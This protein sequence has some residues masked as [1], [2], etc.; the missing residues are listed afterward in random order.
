MAALTS[1][2]AT[3]LYTARTMS[4]AATASDV[5]YQGAHV[6]FDTDTGLLIV[7]Q[8]SDTYIPVGIVVKD[9]TIGAG[10]GN[11]LVRLYRELNAVWCV[12]DS[13]DP[14]VTVGAICYMLDDQTVTLDD[15]SNARSVA[16]RVWAIDSTK[17]VLVEFLHTARP[18]ISGLD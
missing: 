4:L 11:V 5:Y 16:G 10:G 6:G 12:N 8:V 13:G 2:R 15:D 7:G 18:T 1:K 9:T 17:G 14:V 3:K